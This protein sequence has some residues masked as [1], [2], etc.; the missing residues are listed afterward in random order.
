MADS[1]ENSGKRGRKEGSTMENT[2]QRRTKVLSLMLK[3][4]TR[5]EILDTITTEF[6][7]S[8]ASVDHDVMLCNEDLRKVYA[9]KLETLVSTNH[10][11]LEKLFADYDAVDPHL[12]LKIIQEQNKMA[13]VYKPESA[14]QVNNLS[15]NLEN[16]SVSEL[17]ALLE[18]SNKD[19]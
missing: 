15:L 1:D 19:F 16:L 9:E 11:K 14:V 4:K 7:I 12:Q 8:T 6:D 5:E 3:G 17:K 2:R 10:A 18:G 13:G